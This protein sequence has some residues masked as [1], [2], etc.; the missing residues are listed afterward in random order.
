MRKTSDTFQHGSFYKILLKT[1]KVIKNKENLRTSHREEM[2]KETWWLNVMW[3]L[4][5]DP[6]T[7]E[8]SEVK[9]KESWIN[10]NKNVLNCF[11]N[12]SKCTMLMWDI[13]FSSVTQLCPSLCDPMDSSMSGFPFHHQ[14]PELAQ[15]HVHRVG[16]AIHHH[17]MY[18]VN[19]GEIW[20]WYIWEPFVLSSQFAHESKTVLKNKACFLRR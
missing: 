17:I 8:G 16:D 12:C 5:W 7:E 3:Y 4:G 13:Q 1:V 2:P 15:A 19:N 11:I 6:G 9:T 18:D 20:A 14:L 10:F